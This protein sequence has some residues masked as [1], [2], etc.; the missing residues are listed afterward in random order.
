MWIPN[1]SLNFHVRSSLGRLDQ[2]LNSLV[3]NPL[4]VF[5]L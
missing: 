5:L 1:D 4:V 2:L 3:D